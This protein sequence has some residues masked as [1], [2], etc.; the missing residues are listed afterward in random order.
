MS[1]R[2]S[3]HFQTAGFERVERVFAVVLLV[4]AALAPSPGVAQD[5]AP[6]IPPGLEIAYHT[7]RP[8]D[9][10]MSV[11]AAYLGS[12]ALWPTVA[13]L[14]P[15]Y[16]ERR[17][18]PGERMTVLI[19]PRRHVDAARI[20]RSSGQVEE[21][22]QPMDWRSAEADDLLLQRDATRT[23]PRSSAE[24][25]FADGTSLVVTEDS[26]VFL[27]SVAGRLRGATDR[28]VEIV[29]GQADLDTAAR[30][31]EPTAPAGGSVELLM[32]SSR[33]KLDSGGP[34]RTRAAQ[35]EEGRAKVGM[36][37]GDA[38]F[39]S[40][41]GAV[42]LQQGQGVVVA[43]GEEPVPETLLPA[44]ALVSPEPSAR[45][46]RQDEAVFAWRQPE[47]GT[48]S[49]YTVEVCSDPRCGLLLRRRTGV[50]ETSASF[51]D[52]PAG[53][54]Y[55][56]VTAAAPS[57]LD[58]FP[59]EARPLQ[60]EERPPDEIPPVAELELVGLAIPED[61][62]LYVG[63]APD[64][65]MTASDEGT[66]VARSLLEVNGEP[67]LEGDDLTTGDTTLVAFAEDQAGLQARSEPLRLFV[68]ATAPDL[69]VSA[70]ET[71]VIPEPLERR[72]KRRRARDVEGPP[73]VRFA[74]RDDQ[75]LGWSLDG[76]EWRALTE[77]P[78]LVMTQSTIRLHAMPGWCL[79]IAGECAG[80]TVEARARD[81]HVG[82]SR[83][84]ASVEGDIARGRV[85]LV[86]EAVD[87]LGNARRSRFG[88]RRTDS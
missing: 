8:G 79:E 48:A 7:I 33:L 9:T 63:P 5:R 59:S 75:P 86:L 58:G 36:Y 16:R 73:R 19:D 35:T 69:T 47:E 72:R 54:Q 26:M 62:R 66:G 22:P 84:R 1:R 42:A 49:S 3:V 6:E 68:D 51:S 78:V 28:E 23:G 10:F 15:D 82:L 52:L 30:Q 55:W 34:L 43:E 24:L 37:E 12:S 14:N 39:E 13:A 17:L 80:P 21:Q 46:W 4:A 57:G 50:T 64:L 85:T 70:V 27:R 81:E 74:V 88:L 45:W 29:Q 83:L 41:G 20:A 2:P 60:V 65:R 87:R 18:R 61:G 38:A 32:G 76:I 11:T 44:P 25:R 53:T 71:L 67:H 31:E 77:R 56:R 40:P